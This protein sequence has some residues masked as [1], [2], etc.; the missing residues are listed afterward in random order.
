MAAYR[1][2]KW[3]FIIPFLFL[4]LVVVVISWREGKRVETFDTV[5]L[6]NLSQRLDHLQVI[7][8]K[9]EDI[10]WDIRAKNAI[11][12]KDEEDAIVNDIEI[13][14][15]PEGGDPVKLTGE[16]GRYN[17]NKNTFFVEKQEKDVDISIGKGIFIKTGNVEW[18]EDKREIHSHGKVYLKGKKFVLEGEELVANIDSGRYEINKNIRATLWK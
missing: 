8:L 7:R 2:S 12:Y 14:Y 16:K 3:V 17:I 13:I 6:G 15:N 5:S 4:V 1:L 10:E 18:L 11:I 9:G